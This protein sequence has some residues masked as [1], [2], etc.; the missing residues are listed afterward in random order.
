[1]SSGQIIG[2]NLQLPFVGETDSVYWFL[3]DE[4]ASQFTRVF[5]SQKDTMRVFVEESSDCVQVP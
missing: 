1:M 3:G 5:A 4:F 2:L